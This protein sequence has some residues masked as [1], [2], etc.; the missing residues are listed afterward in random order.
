MVLGKYTFFFF[1]FEKKL[2]FFCFLSCLDAD[3]EG[4]VKLNL[5]D[6]PDIED[7]LGEDCESSKFNYIANFE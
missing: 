7:I 2:G 3:V 6:T 5:L 1:N 4:P